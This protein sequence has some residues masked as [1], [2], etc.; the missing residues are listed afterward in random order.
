MKKGDKMMLAGVALCALA[1]VVMFFMPRASAG[2]VEVQVDGQVV[3][4][5]P[6]DTDCVYPIGEGNVME[7]REGKAFMRSATCRD[8]ICVNMGAISRE[9]ETI[10]CL[11]HKV[12]LTARGGEKNPLDAVVK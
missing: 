7:I 9:G 3:A 2:K 8:Q 12:V 10:T 6:L 5:L 1:A 4:T 11:P